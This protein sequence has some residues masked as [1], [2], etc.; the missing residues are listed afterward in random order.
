MYI[1]RKKDLS[2]YYWVVDLFS[3]ASF[4]TIT[5]DFPTNELVIPSIAVEAKQLNRVPFEMGSRVGKETVMWVINIFGE[6][7]SQ[8]DD[9]GYRIINAIEDNIPVND[10]DEGFPPS[11]TPTQIG[12]LIPRSIKMEI[13]PVIPELVNKLYWRAVVTFTAEYTQI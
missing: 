13:I 7:K 6:N 1:E 4:I 11:V 10:Y 2:V 9:F 3:D 5:D 12:C 8:R